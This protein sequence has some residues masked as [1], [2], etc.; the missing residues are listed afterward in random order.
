MG[1]YLD[2]IR[3]IDEEERGRDISDLS[4]KSPTAVCDAMGARDPQYTF[5]RLG[6]FGRTFQELERRCPEYVEAADWQQAVE[7]SRRFLA[8][9]SEQA[10][11]LGWTS[12][13]LFGLHT[14]PDEPRSSYRRL[15]RYDCT[16]LVWLLRGRPVVALTEGT[17]AIRSTTGNVTKY[18]KHDKPA[19]GPLGDSL[20]DTERHE[21]KTV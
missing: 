7:D 13:D 5:G 1:K 2:I 17:A 18:R 4:D 8:Q 21:T 19:L 6:R 15:S 11:A 14:P 3:R 10:L 16:G 12:R 20:G 9:W